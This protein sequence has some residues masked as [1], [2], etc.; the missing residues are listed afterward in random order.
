MKIIVIGDV[1]GLQIWKT[2]IEQ[3]QTYDK[4]IFL[5]DYWDSFDIS[6]IAQRDNYIEIQKFRDE[7]P[8]KVIT[9][10]GNHDYHYIYPAKYSGWKMPTKELAGELLDKDFLAEKLPFAYKWGNIIFS[11]AGITNYWLKEVA[12]TTLEE[13]LEGLIPMH[14]FDWNGIRGFDMYGNTISNSPLW[15]RPQALAGDMLDSYK[16]VVGHTHTNQITNIDDELYICDTL[17]NQYLVIE[18]NKFTIKTLL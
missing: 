8:N 6:P 10:M 14:Y 3:E 4:V 18:L 13:L 17:P 12:K 16:Q 2:I 11:H 9:L 15:V 1:H 7:N 5:G